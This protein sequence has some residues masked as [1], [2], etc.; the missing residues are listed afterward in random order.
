MT[1][2]ALMRRAFFAQ[3]CF[4]LAR[5][6]AVVVDQSLCLSLQVMMLM[7]CFGKSVNQMPGLPSAPS[8]FALVS[9][10]P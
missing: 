2:E 1:A 5:L 8:K 10:P 4:L 9:V 7:P 6:A 3:E